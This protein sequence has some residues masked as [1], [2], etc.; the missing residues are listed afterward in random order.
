MATQASLRKIR[1][2]TRMLNVLFACTALSAGLFYFIQREVMTYHAAPPP[3]AQTALQAND[4]DEI[5]TGSIVVVQRGGD[6]CWRLNF[7][8]RTGAMWAGRYA[9]CNLV[10]ATNENQR[11]LTPDPERMGAISAAFHKK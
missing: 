2:D 4:N 9:D 6:Q 11:R 3:P 7:D 10:T 1:R 5:F 8:N